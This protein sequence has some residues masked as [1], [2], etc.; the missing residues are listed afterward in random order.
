M[1]LYN[2][3]THKIGPSSIDGYPIQY[4][5]NTSPA[6]YTIHG[7]TPENVHFSCGIHPWFADRWVEQ[8]PLLRDAIYQPNVVAIGEAGLDK[9][10]GADMQTQIAA[11]RSQI[12]LAVIHQKP[13]IVHCVKAWEELIA[14][15]KEYRNDAVPWILHGYRGNSEQTK[16]LA[17]LGFLFSI[18][19]K[20]NRDSLKYIPPSSLF[21]ETDDSELS[22]CN[23]YEL[24]CDDLGLSFDQFAFNVEENVNL[25]LLDL[26]K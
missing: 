8:L 24:L 14:L 3:H 10:R 22:I 20:F 23:I 13:L 4:I 11:F 9:L 1:Y 5:L 19:E 2:V 18:G 7:S 17:K 25:Y 12:E 21:C 15:Y 16:Q 26:T 6:E